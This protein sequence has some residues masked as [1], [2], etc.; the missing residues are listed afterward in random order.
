MNQTDADRIGI[1][2]GRALE[3]MRDAESALIHANVSDEDRLELSD[4]V[5]GIEDCIG[6]HEIRCE[7]DGLA[8]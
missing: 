5:C 6:S 4:V 8:V 2:L 7:V 1:L 3:A